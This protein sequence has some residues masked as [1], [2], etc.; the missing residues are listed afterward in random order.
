[1]RFMLH[2]TGPAGQQQQRHLLFL[3]LPGAPARRSAL[4]ASKQTISA[5]T[6]FCLWLRGTSIMYTH[7]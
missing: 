4:F 5:T 6:T 7:R 2:G 3:L 1:M